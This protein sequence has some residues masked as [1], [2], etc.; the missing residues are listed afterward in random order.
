[1]GLDLRS[2][3]ELLH[4]KLVCFITKLI[5]FSHHSHQATWVDPDGVT[6][7]MTV[8][9]QGDKDELTDI[10]KAG[11]DVNLQSNSG[12]T[13]AMYAIM[14]SDVS[15]LEILC[16]HGA[17]LEMQTLTGNTA[18][19]NAVREEEYACLEF[20]LAHNA[21]PSIV[22]DDGDTAISL[23]VQARDDPDP[24][25]DPELKTRIDYLR[26]LLEF[27]VELDTPN[28]KGLTALM[29]ASQRGDVASVELLI[30]AGADLDCV[31]AKHTGHN[32]CM[33]AAVAKHNDI[34]KK[35]LDAGASTHHRNNRHQS[36]LEVAQIAGNDEAFDLL[37]VGLTEF[38]EHPQDVTFD[39][40]TT[41]SL[42]CVCSGNPE[43]TVE[44]RIDGRSV[45]PRLVRQF[46][47]KE[48]Q[49][50]LYK[51]CNHGKDRCSI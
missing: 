28:N 18:I 38:N 30:E 3:G 26:K 14:A 46:E 1:M 29:T 15:C 36:L 33:L 4:Y 50:L 2:K 41:F 12:S 23:L 21:D 47:S 16:S 10:C 39:D 7:L 5:N 24:D 9:E 8:A 19:M 43:P 32:A 13:A 35:L 49:L 45:H 40:K 31:E 51:M 20:L 25:R 44:W 6:S 34:L 22:N 42:T 17:D 27:K 11:A 37:K 48:A